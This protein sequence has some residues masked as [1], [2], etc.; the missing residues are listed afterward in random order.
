M[1]DDTVVMVADYFGGG[2]LLKFNVGSNVDKLLP[3]R[4][5]SNLAAQ[6]GNK[7]YTQKN[8]EAMAIQNAVECIRVCL[9]GNG[10][11]V[12]PDLNPAF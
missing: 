7:F 9:L 11:A 3:P 6:Y 10:C 2:Q 1:D 8:G 4:F 5:W 12:P